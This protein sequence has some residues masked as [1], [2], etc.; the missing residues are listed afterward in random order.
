MS[1]ACFH[2]FNIFQNKPDLLEDSIT[3][4]FKVYNDKDKVSS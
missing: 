3:P 2:F 4:N 1:D